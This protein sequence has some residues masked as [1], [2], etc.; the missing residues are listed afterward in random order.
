MIR[1]L[2]ADDQ[3][4]VRAGLAAIVAVAADLELVGEA[5]DGA[6]A[7][8]QARSLDP[9]VVLMDVRMPRVDGI[10][11]T[12]QLRDHRCQ[13]L[14]LT[15]FDVDEHVLAALRAGA[16]GY[17]LK[18]AT[19]E[20]IVDAVRAAARGETRLAPEVLDHLVAD[21]VGRPGP[22]RPDPARLAGLSPREIEVLS[23]IAAGLSN[24]EIA[25]ALV[26]SETTVKTHVARLLAKL[27]LRDRAQAVAVAYEAGLVVPG[28]NRPHR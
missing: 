13:V 19:P 3:P 15:T 23:Q 25:T 22:G 28:G 7:V 20:V 6:V 11:A 4:L 1:V 9:D 8:S 2:V 10:E 5:D 17:L 18:D 16:I 24:A 21:L 27:R 14:I 12:R 26:V